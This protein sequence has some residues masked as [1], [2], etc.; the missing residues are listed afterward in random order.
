MC[1]VKNGHQQCMCLV[2][3][4]PPLQ[5]NCE[6]LQDQQSPQGSWGHLRYE[7]DFR[8]S[9]CITLLDSNTHNPPYSEKQLMTINMRS[10]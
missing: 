7:G 5:K 9:K 8:V 3:I 4:G 10:L 1:G 2:E 6:V